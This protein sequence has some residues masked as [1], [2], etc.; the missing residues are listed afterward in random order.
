MYFV[1]ILISLKD[2]SRYYIGITEN[3]KERLKKHNSGKQTGYSKRYA[4]WEV[5]T[6]IT[7]KNKLRAE[8]FEKYL[9][10]GSGQAFLKRRFI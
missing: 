8:K 3:L 10:E 4:P 1:Y 7:F 2:P 5:E 6:Y 9:K